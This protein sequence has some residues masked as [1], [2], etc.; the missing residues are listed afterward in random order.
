VNDGDEVRR[1]TNPTN[2]EDDV[3]LEIGDVGGKIVLEG[4]TFA[5]G[6]ANISPE[7]QEIL[8][9]A[10]KTLKAYPD[11]VVEIRGYTDNTGNRAFN[12]KLSERRAI[13]VKNYLVSK[14]IS[15]DRLIAKGYGP[16]DP[17]ADN[18]TA[19]GRRKNRRIEFV[20]VK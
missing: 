1:G 19:E 3:V 7:S 12:V 15:P 2:A 16:A 8:D 18:S 4:I 11:M 17:I 5:S 9:K 10:Y 14:G 6:G 20:R 13:A